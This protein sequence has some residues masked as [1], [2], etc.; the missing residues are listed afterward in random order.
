MCPQYKSQNWVYKLNLNKFMILMFAPSHHTEKSQCFELY[1]SSSGNCVFV[2]FSQQSGK[3]LGLGLGFQSHPKKGGGET[4]GEEKRIGHSSSI[5]AP[6]HTLFFFN[7]ISNMCPNGVNSSTS[8]SKGGQISEGSATNKAKHF[9]FQNKS[10]DKFF[11]VRVLSW[12]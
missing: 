4:E 6:C 3:V 8:D 9:L 12:G 10:P 5:L 2:R 7:L 11:R 1:G